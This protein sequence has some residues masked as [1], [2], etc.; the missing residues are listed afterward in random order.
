[1]RKLTRMMAT[2][3]C[4]I[5]LTSLLPLAAL[6]DDTYKEPITLT[7]FSE[8][9]NFQGEQAGWFGKELKDRFNVTLN[10]VSSNIDPNAYAAGM[11]AGQ[12]GDIIVFGDV[13][14]HFLEAIEADMLLDW[15]ELDLTAFPTLSQYTT[16]A[17]ANISA[18]VKEQKDVEGTWGFG[19]NIGISN[20][21]WDTLDNPTYAMQVRYDAWIKAGKPELKTLQ[22]L[23]PFL[24]ALQEAVPENENGEKV[25]AYGGFGDWE[26]CV[27]KFTWD[28][29]TWYGYSEWD[30]MGVNWA[31]GDVVNPL[32]DDSLY[33]QALKVNNQLYRAG[34]F[35]PE[36]VSQNFDTYSQKLSGGRYLMTLWGWIIN[37]YNN[38]E[39]AE[40]VN[41]FT[42]FLIEDSAPAANGIST[43]GYNRVWTLGADTQYP[44]RCLEILDWLTTE[45][46]IIV[47][48]YGPKGLA[49]DYDADGTPVMT[50]FGWTCYENK[51]ETI[52][53]D[54]FGGG[55]FEDG[56]NKFNNST[57]TVEQIAD[58]KTYSYSHMAWPCGIDRSKTAL[59][60][61]WSAD[62]ANG[63][64]NGV[65]LYK[66]ENKFSFIPADG[67][68]RAPYSTEVEGKRALFAPVMKQN[69]W[70]CVYAET[71]EEFEALWTEMVTT[72][73][74]YGYDDAVA[75][76]M[77][78]YENRMA[79]IAA[80]LAE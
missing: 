36:S 18:F 60:E 39:R 33:K 72:C 22:D 59:S 24:T 1:M 7:V 27:M 66:A 61:A 6:A 43:K 75:E 19:H 52:M 8:L 40:N 11:S 17:L 55:T 70:K 46:G 47:G 15:D 67:Y 73:K 5:L 62:Y 44:E 63:A 48:N 9:A 35:D 65:Q 29:M 79:S 80:F 50:D 58:G 23:V 71:D 31:T 10:F 14:V 21:A 34:L 64:A 12:L 25:Y 54:E 53:P 76:L 30:F 3:L 32:E 42:T 45:E 26:D 28:M 56:E 77:V 69:S 20:D 37:N 57:L 74:E 41:G 2:L 51:K 68:S 13:S 38:A 16:D 4:V 49:W 78:E